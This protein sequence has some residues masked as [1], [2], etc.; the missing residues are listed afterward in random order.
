MNAVELNEAFLAEIAGWDVLKQARSLLASGK[1]Q[2]SDWTPPLLKGTVQEGMASYRAGL[3]IKDKVNIE[4]ICSCRASRSWGAM[5]V[6]SVAVGLHAVRSRQSLPLEKTTA[7]API[8]PQ[9]PKAKTSGD[10]LT[11]ASPASKAVRC[12]QR[13]PEGEGEPAEICVIVPTNFAQAIPKGRIML[14]FEGNWSRGRAPLNALPTT[15]PFRFSE[16]DRVLLEQ[17]E[18]RAEGNTP[19]MLMLSTAGFTRL[20]PHLAGHPRVT[21]GKSLPLSI[22]TSPWRLPVQA[23]LESSGEITL[24]LAA[25]QPP[26]ALMA[27]ETSWVFRRDCIQPVGLP[28]GYQELWQGPMRLPRSRVPPFLNEDWPLFQ[29]HCE[30]TANFRLEDFQLEKKRPHFRLALAGGLAHLQAQLQ[31]VYDARTFTIGIA[32]QEESFWLP[33][34]DSPTRYSTRDTAAEQTAQARLLRAGFTGPHAEGKFQ[35]A[36]QN[37]VLSF[38]ARD[39]P[40]LQREWE[41]TM[42]ERLQRSTSQNLVR[43]APQFA[44]TPSGEQWFDLEVAFATRGGERFSAADIQRL[45][46]SGQS[47]TRLKNGT[48]AL[49]DTGAVEELQEVLL[50]CAPQQDEGGYRMS[51]LQAGF[52]DGALREQEDWRVQAPAQWRERA[53]QQRGEARI[54]PPPLGELEAVLRP[55]QKQ[56]VAWLHFLRQNG[57]G[58][59]LADEMGLGKTLQTL[60][61]LQTVKAARPAASHVLPEDERPPERPPETGPALIVC[62]TSLVFNWVAEAEKFTPRLR[63]LALHGPRRHELFDQMT[64]ADLVIT[65]YALIRRDAEQYR[66]IGFDTVVLD[67]AQHIKN[68]QTQNAQAVKA[69][70]ARHRLVLTGTP[71]ENSVLDLWSIFDFLMPGY[72]GSAADFRERYELPLAREKSPAVQARLARRV[73]PFLLR[74]LKQEVAKDLPE[75]IEQVAF[76]ELTEDQQAVYQQVLEASRREVVNAVDARGL[77]KSRMIILNAL[78]R[79]RQICCDLRLLKLENVDAA[80]ASGK[81]DLFSELLDEALDG[82][83]RLLVFSQFVGMLTL[84]RENLEAGQIPF[85]YLDGATSDRAGVVQRFQ[86]NADI[87]VFLISLKAGGVGL[88]LTGAD[89]VVHFDPWWNPAVEDQATDRAHRIGQTRVVTSYKLIARGTVEEKILHLQARKK[90]LIKG[91]LGGEES[92]SEALTWEEIQDLLS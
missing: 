91:V 40:W 24:R 54:E 39:F 33:D 68:R 70:R 47:H 88:N 77:Q 61:L 26:A 3:V 16:R 60:A 17:I 41:V 50:D 30:L 38:L 5:C 66:Q 83:H 67:E 22:T 86:G 84:L 57:F 29:A 32:S 25:G 44:I 45:V 27:G 46:L 14:Y 48:F 55:Y 18:L 74:R 2:G 87:P 75:K 65:S 85:C 89:T 72:L 20:L 62:P 56:G 9:P 81:L 73:R 82:N 64:K 43:I 10:S 36:G 71:L 49:I 63:V 51:N 59:I 78:L 92:L 12:L 34:A 37:L 13:A 31:C 8:P 11:P 58:G 19:G 42:E 23:A 79:L 1:V 7:A 35:L 53:A 21:L 6:H 4:N 28:K 76:C 15:T 90:E 52:L 80:T 69:V